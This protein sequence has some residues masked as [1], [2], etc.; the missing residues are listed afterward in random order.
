MLVL[1]QKFDVR[2]QAGDGPGQDVTYPQPENKTDKAS[3]QEHSVAVS[4]PAVTDESAEKQ[5][6]K[7]RQKHGECG[8]GGVGGAVGDADLVAGFGRRL[9]LEGDGEIHV[10]AVA[11]AAQAANGAGA[12]TSAIGVV[13]LDADDHLPRQNVDDGAGFDFIGI[14]DF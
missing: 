12:A 13:P 6:E 3:C 5:A 14:G 11:A 8:Y 1:R 7:G 9:T 10:A 4:K 2:L